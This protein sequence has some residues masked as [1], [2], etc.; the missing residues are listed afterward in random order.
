MHGRPG[1]RTPLHRTSPG[2]PPDRPLFPSNAGDAAGLIAADRAMQRAVAE[3]DLAAFAGFLADE[4]VLVDSRGTVH[5]K[6]EVL[7]QAA[8][9]GILVAVNEPHDHQVRLYGEV[10][11]VI[12]RLDQRGTDH[13]RP[14]DIPVRF[15]DVWVR[16]EG[17][18]VCTSGHASRLG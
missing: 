2:L 18:W 5:G 15:T 8:D 3:R 7:R 9:P 16:R 1:G 12:A 14:Y 4:Y 11:V 13:G 10:A 6:A 17:R